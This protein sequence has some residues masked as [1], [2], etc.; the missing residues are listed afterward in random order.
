[1]CNM[2]G[3]ETSRL[4]TISTLPGRCTL[5]FHRQGTVILLGGLLSLA[6]KENGNGNGCGINDGVWQAVRIMSVA[7]FL[8]LETLYKLGDLLFGYLIVGFDLD[9]TVIATTTEIE[10]RK[11][12][13][14]IRYLSVVESIMDE[15]DQVAGNPE[16][17]YRDKCPQA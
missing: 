1:M 10:M 14:Y 11:H 17:L 15:I 2:T 5:P 8:N 16:G 9:T 4:R 13:L 3:T 6:E 12:Q 7:K